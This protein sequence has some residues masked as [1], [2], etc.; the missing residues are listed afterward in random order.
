MVTGEDGQFSVSNLPASTYDVEVSVP[1]FSRNSPG[2]LALGRGQNAGH[3]RYLGNRSSVAVGNR[4]GENLARG[5]GSARWE[6][7]D[8]TSAKTE[9]TE[10]L[11]KNFMAPTTDF[12]EV[13]NL[14]PGT[15]SPNP[16]GI[17]LGQG[18]T[19]FRGF[20]DGQY[21]IPSTVFLSRILTRRHIIPG[22]IFLRS[23]LYGG[24]HRSPGTAASFG[25]TNFGGSINLQ[26][27]VCSQPG[28]S[29]TF[30]YG[31]WIRVF[32]VGR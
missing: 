5:F 6:R 22:P 14:S 26:S 9:I 12:A 32:S 8:T 11:I 1:G 20:P 17:G 13:V 19:F 24:F 4:D 31:S 23:G 28:H 3:L 30:S 16:N 21:T 27:T 15:F 7:P 2:G 25:P 18:N 29:R 10:N